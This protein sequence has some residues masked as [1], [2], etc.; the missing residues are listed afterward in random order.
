MNDLRPI[1]DPTAPATVVRLRGVAKSFDGKPVL[2]G[3]DLDIRHG[4]FLTLLGPSGCGKTTVLRLIAGFEQP[5]HGSIE[6]AG[7]DVS[8]LA[9]D[10]RHV[11]TVF[12]SYALFPHMTVQQNVAFGLEMKKVPK[13]EITARVAETLAVVRLAGLEGRRPHEL[14]GGQQQRVALARAL[15]NRP[16]VL[17]LDE[18]LSA[19]DYKLRK[20][21]Q[22]ELKALQRQLG[23][24][25]VFVTHDQEE[26]LAMSDRVVLLNAGRIAQSGPPREIYERPANLFVAQFVGEAN[27]FSGTLLSVDAGPMPPGSCQW[28]T[29][30]HCA[31]VTVAGTGFHV[32]VPQPW[33]AGTRVNIVVRPEDMRIYSQGEHMPDG[34]PYFTGRIV[35]R[36]Y[37]GVTLDSLI[38]TADGTRVIASEFFDE[39]SP[40]FD[41]PLGEEVRISWVPDWETVLAHEETP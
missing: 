41:H 36:T 31:R 40:D 29:G 9:P 24:T 32:R 33:P 11:N 14:S 2:A 13:A 10:A 34:Q 35:E 1:P 3:L 8:A 22:V 27:I 15:V 6:I 38:E 12:Q 21:M 23:I 16:Q 39:D 19:L 5:D 4:E 18:S 28:N 17:L 25:F 20:Q 37:K 26:A 30:G 7:R